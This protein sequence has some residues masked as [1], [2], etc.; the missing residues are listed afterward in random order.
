MHPLLKRQ[1][2]KFF[3]SDAALPAGIE[4]FVAAISDSYESYDRDHDLFHRAMELSSEELTQSNSELRAVFQAIPDLILRLDREG[5]TVALKATSDTRPHGWSG[6]FKNGRV[7]RSIDDIPDAALRDRLRRALE[8]VLREKADVFFEYALGAENGNAF[9]EV[10]LVPLSDESAIA[11]IQDISQRKQAEAE[12]D[13]LNQQLV[14]A[15]RLAGMAEVAT[16]VLHNVGNVLNSVNVSASLVLSQLR[17]SKITSLTKAVKLLQEHESD[18]GSFLS[19]DPTGQKLPPF[20][21]AVTGQLIQEHTLLT[22]ETLGLQDNIDHIKQIVAMQQSYAKVSGTR[23]NLELHALVEDAL[24][25]SST[26]LT[27]H[28]VE[29]VREFQPIPPVLADRHKVLQILINLVNNAKQAMDAQAEGRRLVLRVRAGASGFAR[30]EVVDNGCGIP[31]GNLARIFSHGFTTKKSGHGFG[32]HSGANAAKEM[33]GSLLVLSDGP[34]TG[35]TF[36][37]EL[38]LGGAAAPTAAAPNQPAPEAIHV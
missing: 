34:G 3:G 35:A 25:M 8:S 18:L 15:S 20:L 7:I 26:S 2:R 6:W 37:L 17:R 23:E 1:V 30:L 28:Q 36:V 9:F 33:G 16:G 31:A 29:V 22:R 4:G 10:R 21:A 27:R 13:R 19:S 11:I 12:H 32:L 38:P 24:R 5:A 14:E